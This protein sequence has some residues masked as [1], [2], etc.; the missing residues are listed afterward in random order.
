MLTDSA[1]PTLDHAPEGRGGPVAPP[2]RWSRSAGEFALVALYGVVLTLVLLYPISLH[3]ATLGRSDSGD[4]RFG[5]WNVSWVA[6]TLAVD[7][8]HLFDANIFYPHHR[9]LAY[10]ES[11]LGAGVLAMPGYWLTRSPFVAYTS[12]MLLLFVLAVIAS[13]Y[14]VRQ[15]TGSRGAAAVAAVCFPFCPYVLSMTAEIQL[16]T[17]FGLPLSLLA[18]HRLADRPGVGRGLVLGIALAMTALCSGYYGI[19]AGLMV[20]WSALVLAVMRPLWRSPRY[21]T[22]LAVGVATS[23][24]IVLPFFLPYVPLA[25]LAAGGDYRPLSEAVLWSAN[26][27]A[28]LTSGAD[29]HRW[30]LSLVSGWKAVLFP[31]F[32]T[33]VLAL[34][35]LSLAGTRAPSAAVTPGTAGHAPRRT[36]TMTLYGSIAVLAAWLS[37]GPH[38]GLYL[39]LDRLLP[40]LFGMVHAP[41][42]FGLVVT[43]AL[44]VLAGL[45]V[46][47]LQ[48]RVRRP[49]LLAGGLC[50]AAALEL[51]AVPLP[52]APNPV[53]PDVYHSVKGLPPGPVLELP[54]Y[55]RHDA[56]FQN[57]IYMLYSTAHWKPLVGGYS[58]YTPPDYVTMPETLSEFPTPASFAILHRLGVHYVV[59]HPGRY[60]DDTSRRVL[61]EKLAQ[62]RAYLRPDLVTNDAW[63]YEVVAWPPEP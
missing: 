4:G 18:F 27:Q 40:S 48:A 14:L 60:Y 10:S 37:F 56:W 47:A 5:I 50:V 26:W 16:L 2:G 1:A 36:E 39:W 35:G 29:A 22:A 8:A 31:G 55:W 52:A 7:P 38:A 6:R 30:L 3:P 44:V 23:A 12:A 42:R 15:V 41:S 24:L 63:L 58:D 54:I 53:I 62:Y 13:Y 59:F 33:L 57:T 45:G 9:T 17:T 34:T 61:R 11:N 20:G 46:A 28:Y 51:A 49:R 19:F 25:R 43:L 32:L 21:W